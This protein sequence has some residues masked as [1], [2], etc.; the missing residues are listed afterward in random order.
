MSL[1]INSRGEDVEKMQAKLGIHVDGV[2][3]SVTD[4][5]IKRLSS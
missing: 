1:Q 3:G 5:G 2:F 4:A